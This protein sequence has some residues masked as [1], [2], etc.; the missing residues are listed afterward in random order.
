MV[1]IKFIS[2][3]KKQGEICSPIKLNDPSSW[4]HPS[5]CN[6]RWLQ[7]LLPQDVS[8]SQVSSF[9][10]P[11]TTFYLVSLTVCQCPFIHWVER[12]I[13]TVW[14]PVLDHNNEQPRLV[15][16]PLPHINPCTNTFSLSHTYQFHFFFFKLQSENPS[17]HLQ[18]NLSICFH[19]S[20]IHKN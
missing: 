3:P 18:I 14:Y 9:S 4:A 7:V 5:L 16:R 19:N 20:I 15:T 6:M 17:F 1:P 2:I 11:P 10:L 12:E 13:M 8:P